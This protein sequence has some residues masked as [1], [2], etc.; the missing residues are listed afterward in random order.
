M[1][2]LLYIVIIYIIYF[3]LISI[4]KCML[5]WTARA[6]GQ[7][8]GVQGM[9]ERARRRLLERNKVQLI[10]PESI[11]IPSA[12][13]T[14]YA[15]NPEHIDGKH[16]AKVFESALGYTLDNYQDL[17]DNVY[18][19]INN[20][21]VVQIGNNEQGKLYRCDITITGPNG[22]TAVVRTGWIM[23]KETD[24]YRLTTIFVL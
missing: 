9:I 16:K 8:Y 17:I 20:F 15:L 7:A 1:Y 14:E 23:K 3:I 22:R 21:P 5:T 19:N 18:K 11:E 6:S 2:C 24:F 4:I 10:T 13:L 12:R